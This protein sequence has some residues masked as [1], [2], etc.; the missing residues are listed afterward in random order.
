ME[1]SIDKEAPLGEKHC[2]WFTIPD[3]SPSLL[4]FICISFLQAPATQS[5]AP[6]TSPHPPPKKYKNEVFAHKY[7]LVSAA[8]KMMDGAKRAKVAVVDE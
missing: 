6:P 3:S 4:H 1:Q 2:N 8:S 5:C 7:D